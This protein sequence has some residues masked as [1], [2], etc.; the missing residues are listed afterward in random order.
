MDA[1]DAGDAWSRDGGLDGESGVRNR[2]AFEGG[3]IHFGEFQYWLSL[4]GRSICNC[5]VFVGQEYI[6]NMYRHSEVIE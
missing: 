3:E 1:W 6:Y 2:R 4:Y 5:V